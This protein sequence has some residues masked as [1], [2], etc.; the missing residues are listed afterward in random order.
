MQARLI[1]TPCNLIET[2]A[3]VCSI[4][5]GTVVHKEAFFTLRD[6]LCLNDMFCSSH[7]GEI[8]ESPMP[9][10]LKSEFLGLF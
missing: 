7:P 9:D 5:A 10:D 4:R 8:G 6:R 2:Q 3:L 1:S